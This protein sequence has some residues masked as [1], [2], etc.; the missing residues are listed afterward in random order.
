MNTLLIDALG[1]LAAG[2]MLATFSVR[3]IKALRALAIISNLLFIAYA[4]GAGLL[5]V[6]ALH[7]LLL[8][9]N[10]LRLR[11]VLASDSRAG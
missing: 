3:S 7:A 11:E 5:P 8:P 6:L 1:Y 2:A 4:I 10:L 9:L